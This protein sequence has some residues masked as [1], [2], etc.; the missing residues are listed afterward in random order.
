MISSTIVDFKFSILAMLSRN[1]SRISISSIS[2]KKIFEQNWAFF[3]QNQSFFEHNK[4]ETY[5]EHQLL[6]NT[7]IVLCTFLI[8]IWT[9]HICLSFSQPKKKQR[10]SIFP[11]SLK[12]LLACR[13]DMRSYVARQPVWNEAI[14]I[15]MNFII[16]GTFGDQWGT[17][18]GHLRHFGGL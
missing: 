9:G 10:L 3:K 11:N 1:W 8:K 13:S 6:A 4:A 18:G 7:L 16:W 2:L 15:S 5:C 17:F 12:D 14:C